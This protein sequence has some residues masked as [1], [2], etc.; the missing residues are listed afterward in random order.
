M[1]TVPEHHDHQHHLTPEEARKGLMIHAIAYV[2]VNLLLLYI[3]VMTPGSVWFFWPLL[4]WGIGLACH[5][6]AV[7]KHTGIPP[8]WRRPFDDFR[9]FRT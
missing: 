9:S 4:G 8:E 6:W 3:D 5:A 7:Y 1:S 2:I